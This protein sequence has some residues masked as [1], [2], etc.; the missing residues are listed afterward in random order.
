MNQLPQGD[1]KHYTVIPYFG[2]SGTPKQPLPLQSV[3][4]LQKYKAD[5]APSRLE[6]K[7]LTR[8]ECLPGRQK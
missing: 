7:S 6:F 5:R 3:L 1:M 8:P 4:L 2:D